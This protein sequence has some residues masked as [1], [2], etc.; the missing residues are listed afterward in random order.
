VVVIFGAAV[1]PGG[2]PSATLRR[3]VEAAAA[4]AARF[5]APVFVP[6]G[7]VGRFGPSEASVMRGLLLQHGVAAERILLDES[8]TDTLS[9]ARAVARILRSRE[10]TDTVFV[11][12]S[13][14][15]LARCVM[16]LRMFGVSARAAG[17]PW[18]RA[19][20]WW[21]YWWIREALALPYDAVAA[22]VQRLRA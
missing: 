10:L 1:R 6:T 13:A 18:V 16:L 20:P 9:S 3:R 2:R 8:G 14:F 21:A 15:H 7:A 5:A 11:A 12:S 17:P 22:C 4:F 19:G